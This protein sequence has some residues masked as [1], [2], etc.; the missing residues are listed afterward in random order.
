MFTSEQGGTSMIERLERPIY[1][2]DVH[3]EGQGFATRSK[4]NIL[5]VY[6]EDLK[7]E[8]ETDLSAAPEV[9]AGRRRL[10]LGGEGGIFWGEPHLALN[11]IARSPGRDR[12]C[13]SL[14]PGLK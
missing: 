2:L 12:A 5:T 1:A 13:S 4:T 8:F 3:P 6:G 11:C 7:V 10:D 9:A 14:S